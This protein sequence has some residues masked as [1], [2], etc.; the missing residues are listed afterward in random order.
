ML[1]Q[2]RKRWANINPTTS[3]RVV[4]S[5]DM[6][7]LRSSCIDLYYMDIAPRTCSES[8]RVI[9]VNPLI[10]GVLLKAAPGTPLVGRV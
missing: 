9:L 7:S 1:G 5:V 6:L 8:R 2:R 10:S 4:F 3:Q